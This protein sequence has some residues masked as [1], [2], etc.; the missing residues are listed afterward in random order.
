M[1]TKR[2]LLIISLTILLSGLS[3]L[4]QGYFVFATAKS[5]V[6]DGF[7]VANTYT[8][9][10]NVNVAFLWGAN[11]AVPLVS[12]VQSAVSY[13]AIAG[14]YASGNQNGAYSTAAA[15]NDILNDPNFTLAVD[16]A[17]NALVIA[18]S[19]STGVVFY[20]RY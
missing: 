13:N 12:S 20:D 11:G 7:S 2:L 1:K 16:S 9:S 4:G 10:T 5:A 14:V 15:W 19:T 8:R 17:S 6:W 18:R 3:S